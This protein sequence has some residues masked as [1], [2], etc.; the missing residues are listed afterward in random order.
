VRLGGEPIYRRDFN[1]FKENFSND[2]VLVNRLGSS[3]TGSL[4]MLFL[5]RDTELQTHLVP[6][7]HAVP[8]NDILLLDDS[9]APVVGDEGEIAVRTRYVS[10]G[11]WRRPD[12]TARSFLHDPVDETERI[13]RTGDLGR[14]SED[15]CLF[16]LGRKDFFVKVRGYRVELEE[17]EM[18]LLEMPTVKEAVVLALDN[19]S[20]HERLVAY[21]VPK[22]AFGPAINEVRQFL[23]D[24]LPAY[25]IPTSFIFL[26]AL[27]LTDTLKVDR[28][29]LPQPDGL[30]PEIGVPY[31]A[32]RNFVEETLVKI[33][34]D[35][36]D[37]DRVGIHDSFFDLG[38]HSLAATRIVSRV[39]KAFP[40][41]L[42]LK[43]FFDSP[44]V[45]EMA[46]VIVQNQRENSGHSE[47]LGVLDELESLSDKE[48]KIQVIQVIR[49]DQTD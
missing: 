20:G 23:A 33:W 49:R 5:D 11:Y 35:I 38:G 47:S 16:H 40:S 14:L 8:D 44:T 1:L 12:L 25:M 27:P 7:G 42:P 26:E 37:V 36:L 3:E 41:E 15:G 31:E 10:P 29:A 28:K 4:R 13:Y 46:E 9:G 21:V 19:S 2:C 48:T 43:V 30:R 32:P 45:A 6:V 39:V 24:K 22:T 34:A 18:A 17:I